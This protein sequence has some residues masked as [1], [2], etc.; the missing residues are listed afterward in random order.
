M[1]PGTEGEHGKRP[2][3]KAR[4]ESQALTRDTP[5]PRAPGS[6][7]LQVGQTSRPTET[8][9]TTHRYLDR[10]NERIQQPKRVHR[11]RSMRAEAASLT[12]QPLT[13]HRHEVIGHRRGQGKQQELKARAAT[14]AQARETPRPKVQGSTLLLVDRSLDSWPRG[15]F[16]PAKLPA[17]GAMAASHFSRD[18][19]GFT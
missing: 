11:H 1:T 4:A 18:C 5:R 8:P 14:Q 17:A 2:E 15:V 12:N 3:P 6:T 19:Q 7:L 10:G 9:T 13:S 16:G